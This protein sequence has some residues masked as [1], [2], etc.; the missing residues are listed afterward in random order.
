MSE[1]QKRAI[2]IFA[3]ENGISYEAALAQITVAAVKLELDL[4]NII[5]FLSPQYT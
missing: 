4:N 1:K 3:E 2:E 5:K